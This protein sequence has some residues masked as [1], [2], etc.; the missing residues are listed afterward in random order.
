MITSTKKLRLNLLASVG[1]VSSLLIAAH[2]AAAQQAGPTSSGS[3]ET[4]LVTAEKRS[5]DL[6]DVP[7]A[8]S[9]LSGK[10]LDKSTYTGVADALSDV[11]GVSITTQ[12]YTG[13]SQVTIRGVAASNTIG[14]GSPTVG[15]YIDGVPFGIS[16]QPFFPNPDVYDLA[17]IEVLKGPQGTL[18]GAGS[19]NGV[20]RVLT[21]DPDLD[22]FGF[23][24]RSR[25]SLTEGGS[26]NYN[27]DVAINVPIIQGKLAVRGTL[28]YENDSGWIDSPTTN[29]VNWAK[30][31][32]ARVKVSG[33]ITDTLSVVL[34]AWVSGTSVG[35]KTSFEAYGLKVSNDFQDFSLASQTSYIHYGNNGIVSGEPVGFVGTAGYR[36]NSN[37]LSEEINAVSNSTG[38]WIWSAGTF[39]R[40]EINPNGQ[41]I[42]LSSGTVVQ[43]STS[44]N[45]SLSYAVFGEVGRYL[46]SN[47]LEISLGLRYF[48]DSARQNTIS[49]LPASTLGIAQTPSAATTPRAVLTWKPDD[50]HMIYASYSQGF[51]SGFP[52]SPLLRLAA[53]NIPALKPDK[54]TNYEIGS[55]GTLLDGRVS[56]DGALYYIY[57]RGIQQDLSVLCNCGQPLYYG[58]L[59]NG[60]SASGPGADL[61]LT[62]EVMDGLKVGANVSWSGLTEDKDVIS[63]N[64]LYIAQGERGPYSPEFTAGGSADYTFPFADTGFSGQFSASINYVSGL[65]VYLVGQSVASP[66]RVSVGDNLVTARTSLS[67]L[68]PNNWAVKLYVDNLTNNYPVVT[69]DANAT[70]W[71]QRLRPRTFGVQLDYHL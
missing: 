21:E 26:D 13:G 52:Q 23:K 6:Q 15:Y 12:Q 17:R 47:E 61:N 14:G 32:N 53:P 68:A 1:A 41:S 19:L 54:L 9:V 48:H 8:I 24:A 57:W 56:Y 37:V 60:S 27:G 49:T 22:V 70:Q 65:T 69:R 71:D 63:N 20:V 16:G 28:G 30:Q 34:S 40:Y 25:Y 50:D 4:V 31:L 66:R 67:L 35:D 3:V 5:E 10:T 29:G 18:Y 64:L 2:P 45:S 38:P 43:S 58:A 36:N 62:G 7:I 33:K 11:S 44:T 39:Y 51:R 55:K 42:A 59:V 46:F